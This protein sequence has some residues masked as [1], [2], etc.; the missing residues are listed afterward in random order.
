MLDS[1]KRGMKPPLIGR[2]LAGRKMDLPWRLFA[3]ILV[4]WLLVGV[5]PFLFWG[6]LHAAAEFANAFGFVNALFAALAFG[7]V[8]WAIRLQTKE[9]ELQRMEIEETRDELRRSADAQTLSQEMHFVSALLTARN[10]VTQGYAVAAER[11]TGSLRPNATAHRQ[12]LVELEWLLQRVDQHKGNPFELPPIGVLVAHQAQML[13]ARAHSPL[14]AALANRATNYVRTLLQDLNQV[15]RELRRLLSQEQPSEF[16]RQLD[17]TIA[18]AES[19]TTA[20]EFE[21]IAQICREAFNQ[22]SR[23]VEFELNSKCPLLLLPTEGEAPA[24]Q[25]QK[26]KAA[27]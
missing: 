25:I 1:L 6:E 18:L 3:G 26:D 27:D 4:L 14:Q 23:Q 15:L 11:E 5:V 24:T 17:R 21:E 16:A 12:H 2:L 13:L 22:L 7:G 19:A 8:I 10:G 20:N 9:L